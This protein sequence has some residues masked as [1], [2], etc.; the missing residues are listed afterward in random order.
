MLNNQANSNSQTSGQRYRHLFEHAPICIFVIDI[1][2]NP[3]TILEINRQAELVYGYRADELAGMP[4]DHL[5]AEEA[6]AAALATVQRVQQ[7]QIVRDE[8]SHRRRDGTR[9]PVRLI[10]APDP[11]D[12]SQM[13]VTVEDI[14]A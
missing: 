2:T 12:D 4:A 13:I 3:A 9:F 5:V 6:K 10:A 1:T 11:T 8:A 7:G 14:T